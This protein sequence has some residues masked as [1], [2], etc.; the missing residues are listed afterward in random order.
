MLRTK[1]A[2][3]HRTHAYLR[4][5]TVDQ[6]RNVLGDLIHV[7]MENANAVKMMNVHQQNFVFLRNA[8]VSNHQSPQNLDCVDV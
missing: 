6:K 5:V 8:T 4:F 2:P 1:I 7:Q 3:V